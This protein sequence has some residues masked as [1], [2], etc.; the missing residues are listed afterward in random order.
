MP[1]LDRPDLSGAQH[2]ARFRRW[3]RE[4]VTRRLMPVIGRMLPRLGETE[5][6]ALEA[7]TVWWDGEL[8]RGAPDWQR[9]LDFRVA[10][11]SAAERAFLDGPVEEICRSLDDWEIFQRGDLPAAVWERLRRERFF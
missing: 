3:R 4:L 10:E 9:L 1:P 8:F 7:G 6:E 11:L 5:R 2:E